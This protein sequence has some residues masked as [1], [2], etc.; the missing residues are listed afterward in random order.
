[1]RSSHTVA[2][3]PASLKEF[4]GR[5]VRV[6]QGSWDTGTG[7]MF[8]INPWHE[9]LSEPTVINKLA[10]Y[11]YIRGTLHARISVTANPFQ[12][13]LAALFYWPFQ[14]KISHCTTISL[15]RAI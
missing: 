9:F 5:P 13:G 15:N 3:T 12:Y 7:N 14:N 4:L 11:K 10:Y 1:M 6:R 2:D 8:S